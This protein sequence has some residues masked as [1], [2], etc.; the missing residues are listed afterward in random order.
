MSPGVSSF[1]FRSPELRS[2]CRFAKGGPR[3]RPRG[4]ETSRFPKTLFFSF[5][6]PDKK[7]TK[8]MKILFSWHYRHRW[9]LGPTRLFL[10]VYAPQ[11]LWPVHAGSD[12]SSL[13]FI[14]KFYFTKAMRFPRQLISGNYCIFSSS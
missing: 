10:V 9:R 8:K 1:L 4:S 7:H 6:Y 2:T 14:Y 13:S 5:L 11:Q 12:D 3:N